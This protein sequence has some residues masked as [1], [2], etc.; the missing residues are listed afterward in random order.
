MKVFVAAVA[1]LT[2]VLAQGA[3]SYSIGAP[4][5]A[6]DPLAPIPI[7]HLAAGPQT[8]AVPYTIDISGFNSG[9]VLQYTPGQTYTR[10]LS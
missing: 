8:T 6:C 3:A 7:A 10:K 9:G 2:L 5:F 4:S 1:L